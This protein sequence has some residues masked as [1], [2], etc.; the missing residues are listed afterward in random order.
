MKHNVSSVFPIITVA[1]I[2]IN[3]DNGK[4]IRKMTAGIMVCKPNKAH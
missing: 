3:N 2:H 4:E 1:P